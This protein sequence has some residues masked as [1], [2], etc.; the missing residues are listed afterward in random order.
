MPSKKS[1]TEIADS[2]PDI[3]LKDYATPRQVEALDAVAK[4]TSILNAALELGITPARVRGLLSEARRR[5]ALRGWSPAH[6]MKKTVPDGFHVKG[7]ST[8]YDRQGLVRGQ[9]VK[10][11]KD[12]Q[13]RLA[14][15]AD[16]CQA[17]L[18]PIRGKSEKFRAPR[19][20]AKD[21]LSVY[22]IG[23]AHI[24]MLAWGLETLG[25]DFDLKVAEADLLVAAAQL[26]SL[27][28]DSEECLIA[29]VGDFTHV[30]DPTNRTRRGGNLLDADSRWAKIM[31]VAVSVLRKIVEE[32]LKKHK[33]V[34]LRSALGNHDPDVAIMLGLCLEAYFHNNPRVVVETSPAAYWYYEFG[35]NLVGITHGDGPKL[36]ALGEIM[37][38]DTPEA[39]GRTVYR[40]WVTGH[41]H[42][43]QQKELRGCTADTLRTCAPGDNWHV[44][45]GYRSGRGMVCVLLDREY[46]EYQRNTVGIR[47]IRALQEES[48]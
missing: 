21:T 23:D 35:K 12:Q 25:E 14:E 47:K 6:D 28:P 7:V 29:Q 8:Y 48:A 40:W 27:A 5:A 1:E 26:V 33:I 9:W 44:S 22:G 15:F 46:G 32:A 43:L 16:A 24:G 10:S 36:D 11:Q 31:R 45:A 41:V 18:E 34:R 42:H 13:H 2:A 19:R 38:A 4:H 17:A 37:A 39:W 30:N 20:P 3:D